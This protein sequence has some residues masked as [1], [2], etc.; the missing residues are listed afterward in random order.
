MNKYQ[1]INHFPGSIQLGRKDMLWKNVYRLWQKFGKDFHITPMTYLLPED[2][3][4]FVRDREMEQGNALYI[5]KP[6][7]SSCGR[8]IKVI[9][10]KT[11]VN[12]KE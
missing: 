7:A 9:G 10:K 6:A 12:R 2:Y 3:D 4:R 8:G 11:V 5:L 1:K